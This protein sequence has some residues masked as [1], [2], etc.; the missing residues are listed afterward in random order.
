M[1][2]FSINP[3]FGLV[4]SSGGLAADSSDTSETSLVHKLS[5]S[6][7]LSSS[8]HVDRPSS[9][10][11][12]PQ[13]ARKPNSSVFAEQIRQLEIEGH[14]LRS[15][16]VSALSQGTS[17]SLGSPE[18]KQVTSPLTSSLASL[19]DISAEQKTIADLR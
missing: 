7:P 11:L 10:T 4:D 1:D 16:T 6:L 17:S 9:Y 2:P 5:A 13:T 14:K 18:I 3:S 12:S 19:V 8:I 15:A